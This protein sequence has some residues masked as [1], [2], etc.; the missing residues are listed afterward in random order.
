MSHDE[1]FVIEKLPVHGRDDSASKLFGWTWG[2]MAMLAGSVVIAQFTFHSRLVTIGGAS[3][4]YVYIKRVKQHLPERFIPNLVAHALRR[5]VH[6]RAGGRD[7]W[8][9]PPIKAE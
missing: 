3:A 5:D 2:E 1:E 9:R 8:W 7:M 6:Y 4:T